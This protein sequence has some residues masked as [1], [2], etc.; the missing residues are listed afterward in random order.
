MSQIGGEILIIFLLIVANGMFAMSEMAV[1]TA[2][3][4]RLQDWVRLGNRR[5][6]IALELA[7]APNRFLPAVQIGIT[8]VGI[9]AGVFAGRSVADGMAGYITTIP[10][11]APYHHE[12][13]LGVVV[14]AITY[15]SLVIGELVPKRLALRHPERIATYVAVPLKIGRAHV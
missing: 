12:I 3:K 13:G 15:L 4:S 7:D 11:V 8:V 14:V 10:L 2:R 5:A 9:L 1:I 6:K